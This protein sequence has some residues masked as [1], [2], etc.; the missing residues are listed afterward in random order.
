MPS[1]HKETERPCALTPGGQPPAPPEVFQ[2]WTKS[3][4]LSNEDNQEKGGDRC[5]PPATKRR[6]LAQLSLGELLLSRAHLRFAGRQRAYGGDTR[7]SRP[8][9]SSVADRGRSEC[10][11]TKKEEEAQGSGCRDKT[12]RC[13]G[14]LTPRFPQI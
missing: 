4:I 5:L 11:K 1:Q 8:P 9:E 7:R 3:D 12:S 10:W 13:V 14:Q 6:S 2:A